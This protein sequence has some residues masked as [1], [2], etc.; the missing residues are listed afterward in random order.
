MAVY[1]TLE[2][3]GFFFFLAPTE[4]KEF[5]SREFGT[6]DE[7]FIEKSLEDAVECRLIHLFCF[8][9]FSFE[10]GKWEGSLSLKE[11]EDMTPMNGREHKNR[12]E[13]PV[14]TMHFFAI[15]NFSIESHTHCKT[16]VAGRSQSESYLLGAWR[17]C[18]R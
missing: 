15:A 3:H 7:S 4:S 12:Q 5:F 17:E 2:L 6:V 14:Y 10:F 18:H 11:S 9:E 13:L 8:D 1:T 16:W